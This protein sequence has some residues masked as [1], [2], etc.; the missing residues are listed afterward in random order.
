VIVVDASAV[1]DLVVPDTA[2]PA[3]TARLRTDVDLHAPHLLDV[4]VTQ[5]LRRLV[6]RGRVGDDRASDARVDVAVLPIIRHPHRRLLERAWQLRHNLSVYDG[7]YVALAELLQ[8][9]LVTCDA[10]LAQSPGHSAEV[11]LFAAS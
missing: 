3:L 8:A 11:E 7:V 10:R 1:V 4:E 9:P 2:N 5:A 6:A